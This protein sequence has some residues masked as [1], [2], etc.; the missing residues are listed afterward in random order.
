MEEKK[1]SSCGSIAVAITINQTMGAQPTTLSLCANC[2]EFLRIDVSGQRQLAPSV[3]EL[4]DQ[5][6]VGPEDSKATEPCPRCGLDSD[7]VRRTGQLGCSQCY[8]HFGSLLGSLIKKIYGQRGEGVVH[9]G[10]FPQ[11]LETYRRIMVDARAIR[12]QLQWALE[13]EDYEGAADLRDTLRI[14]LGDS[15][16]A[17]L[18][19][20]PVQAV[21]D[22]VSGED[23]L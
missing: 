11:R 21:G 4:F 16:E 23:D 17:A 20:E 15:K 22:E 13:N 12:Q 10:K 18:G 9:Q 2:A 14:V 3:G 5:L 6:L 7:H 8:E 1:C 19:D